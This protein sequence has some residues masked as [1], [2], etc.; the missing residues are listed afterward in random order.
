M[1]S[2]FIDGYIPVLRS[3]VC[4]ISEQQEVGHWSDTRA[5]REGVRFANI[6]VYPPTGEIDIRIGWVVQFNVI[7][8]CGA[9]KIWVRR[10]EG[11]FASQFIDENAVID[12]GLSEINVGCVDFNFSEFVHTH[13]FKYTRCPHAFIQ[14][15]QVCSLR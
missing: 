7:R 5:F 1:G 15:H 4:V 14:I 2:I 10:T 8:V 3:V 12:N 11:D 6:I 9:I 13:L